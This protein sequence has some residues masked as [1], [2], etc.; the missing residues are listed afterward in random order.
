MLLDFNS[1]ITYVAQS[2]F[3][4][5][6]PQINRDQFRLL[7]STA[8][9][10][11][12]EWTHAQV[13]D[14]E[15]ALPNASGYL[16]GEIQWETADGGSLDTLTRRHTLDPVVGNITG[17]NYTYRSLFL[18]ANCRDEIPGILINT[19]SISPSALGF[20][21]PHG[22]IGND[23]VMFSAFSGGVLPAPLV[24]GTLYRAVPVGGVTITLETIEGSPIQ[25]TTTGSGTRYMRF[26]TGIP[27]AFEVLPADDT[28][29]DDE[30]LPVTVTR[31]V[32][33]IED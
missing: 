12:E 6:I 3:I 33:A 31:F 18:V 29:D 14:S 11:D 19:V 27:I 2:L 9:T 13:F 30:L 28:L 21:T 24:A 32:E 7:V 1:W 5:G 8:S 22:R 4:P 17:A 15:L 23:L 16:R 10:V 26:A 20:S 25:F